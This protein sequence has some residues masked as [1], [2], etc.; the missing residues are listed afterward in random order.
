MRNASA[1]NFSI[2]PTVNYTTYS[3]SLHTQ[4]PEEQGQVTVWK[5]LQ[6]SAYYVMILL[7]LIGNTVVIKTIKRIGKTL[8]R[9]VHYLFIVN[10]SA[11][12]LL[13]ALENIPMACT[14][15]LLNGAWKIE[16][17]FGSFLC[18][19]D[20]FLSLVL[21]LT[22]NL[23][24]LAIAVE[25]FCGIFFP[26]R[27]FVSRKRTFVI[28]ASTWLVSGIYA[29]VLFSSSFAY[30]R[31]GHDGNYRCHLCIKCEKVIQ[32]FIFQTVLLA[33][34]FLT[35]LILYSATGIKIWL[36]TTPGVQLQEHQLRAQAKKLKAIKMLA[37]LVVVFYISFIPFWIYQLSVFLG[38]RVMLGSYYGQISAFLMYCNGAINPLIYSIYNLDIRGEFKAIFTCKKPLARAR[39]SVVTFQSRRRVG[40]IEMCKLYQRSPEPN[41]RDKSR[42]CRISQH[43]VKLDATKLDFVFEDTRL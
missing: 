26:M 24:I 27:T 7:S 23:T 8:R 25:K 17:R 18:R 42:S 12:D 19:F 31:K 9:Q 14:H 1:A 5:I 32:W 30:L 13:F 39:S 21:I 16:G 29:S 35:T 41:V 4:L 10:L 2:E 33:T 20:F 28:I 6:V 43:A 15:L 34:G 11:A 22:S 38:F 37:M 3:D 40:D 36:R